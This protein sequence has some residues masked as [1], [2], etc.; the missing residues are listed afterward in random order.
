M[1][2]SLT[3]QSRV[4]SLAGDRKDGIEDVRKKIDNS[5][6]DE[7]VHVPTELPLLCHAVHLKRLHYES[8]NCQGAHRCTNHDFQNSG[9]LCP[10]S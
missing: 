10:Y 5:L 7:R 3:S 9:R 1:T 4:T 8:N 2:E 6:L